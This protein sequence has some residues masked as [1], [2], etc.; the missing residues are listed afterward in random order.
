MSNKRK[1]QICVIGSVVDKKI[2]KSIITKAENLGREI[3]RH[4]AV[5][6]FGREEDFDS[7]PQIAAREAEKHGGQ[8]IAFVCEDGKKGLKKSDSQII[9]TGQRRGGGREFSL[10][11]SSDAIICIGGKSGTLMEVAM[12]YQA[13]IPTIALKGTGGWS[14]RLIDKFLDERRRQRIIKAVTPKDAVQLALKLVKNG[15]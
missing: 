1:I 4:N 11:L 13:G 15:V 10:V 14:D 7:L 2:E 3:A 6:L 9:I 8:T 5:L 12:A